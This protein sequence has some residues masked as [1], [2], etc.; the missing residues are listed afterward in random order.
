MYIKFTRGVRQMVTTMT[1]T[2]EK[3]FETGIEMTSVIGAF[4]KG[5]KKMGHIVIGVF[6]TGSTTWFK[7]LLNWMKAN[8]GIKVTF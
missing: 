5:G 1:I 2:V 4:G 8:P 7:V 3:A 6:P